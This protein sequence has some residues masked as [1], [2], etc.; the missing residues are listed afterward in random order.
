MLDQVLTYITGHFAEGIYLESIAQ[1]VAI[2]PKYLSRIFKER[3]GVNLSE[4]IS[5]VRITKAKEMLV[6]SD[7]NV[8]EIGELVGFENRTTFFRTFKKLEGVSPNEYR[9]F[10]RR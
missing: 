3:T 1:A 10:A 2:H 5:L 4:Y 8:T 6:A 9:R 7:R